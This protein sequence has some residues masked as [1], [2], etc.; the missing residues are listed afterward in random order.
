M[1]AVKWLDAA[2][3]REQMTPEQVVGSLLTETAG[4]LVADNDDFL[5]VGLD[6]IPL[7]GQ[8]RSITAIPQCCVQ[9][10]RVIETED[11]KKQRRVR[12]GT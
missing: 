4:F 3:V 12:R 6:F 1:V 2:Y 10:V 8:Y 11:M 9:E 5:A 7:T